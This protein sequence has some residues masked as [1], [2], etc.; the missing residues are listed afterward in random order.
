MPIN[1]NGNE[2]NSLGVKLLTDTN[3]PTGS[4]TYYWDAGLPSSYPGSGTTWTDFMGNRNGTLNNGP[5][6]S[7]G[8]GGHISFDG[9][10]DSCTFTTFNLGNGNVPWTIHAWI[11]TTSGASTSLGQ[12][13]VFS[14]TSPG[15][16]YSSIGV[17]GNTISYYT[18]Y[19][20]WYR[21]AGSVN[22][23]DNTWRLLTWVQKSNYYM[24][25]YVNGTLDLN[26]GYAES[27]NNNPIDVMGASW[28]GG[29]QCNIG[30]VAVYYNLSHSQSQILQYYNATRQRFGV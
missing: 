23:S 11:R 3:I 21:I 17:T 16:V 18:Y 4:L 24:D 6:Y 27:G 26:N 12:G 19:G 13:A 1:V 8:N 20:G 5:A 9:S 14:N 15:P 10:N 29:F 2:I 7:T 30:S 25:G 22:V 28:V